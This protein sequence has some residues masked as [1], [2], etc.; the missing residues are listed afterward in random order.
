M[1]R[2]SMHPY[3]LAKY[4]QR[5]VSRCLSLRL[6]LRTQMSGLNLSPVLHISGPKIIEE[7]ISHVVFVFRGG[8]FV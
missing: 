4:S 2:T 3:N 6:K 5:C 7:R 8:W 1:Y